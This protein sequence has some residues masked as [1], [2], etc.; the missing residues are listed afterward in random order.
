ML[1]MFN[2]INTMLL[3]VRKEQENKTKG[4]AAQNDRS[5]QIIKLVP[6]L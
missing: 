5:L 6:C 3:A 2:L 4:R 1:I